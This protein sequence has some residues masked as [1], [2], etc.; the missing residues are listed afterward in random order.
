MAAKT[1]NV[2]N[3]YENLMEEKIIAELLK[4]I[5]PTIEK[6]TFDEFIDAIQEKPEQKKGKKSKEKNENTTKK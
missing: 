2:K 1:D 3:A 5:N 6:V 4:R